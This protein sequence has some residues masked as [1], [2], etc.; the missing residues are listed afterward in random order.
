[1]S[2]AMATYA[3]MPILIWEGAGESVVAFRCREIVIPL[4]MTG[5]EHRIS[6]LSLEAECTVEVDAEAAVVAI[7][8][9][10]VSAVFLMAAPLTS[11]PAGAVDVVVAM[12]VM[13]V[14]G[15]MI[16]AMTA[17]TVV[18]EETTGITEAPDVMIEMIVTIVDAMAAAIIAKASAKETNGV[19]MNATM[20]AISKEIALTDGETTEMNAAMIKGS[21][22]IAAATSIPVRAAVPN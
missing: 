18:A 14:D 13:T 6:A 15:A 21:A 3:L 1:M 19:A 17:M 5:V 11:A 16:D 7:A 8:V 20:P 22:S 9:V 10:S 2:I 4:M 12:T